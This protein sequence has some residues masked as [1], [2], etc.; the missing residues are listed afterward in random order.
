MSIL[1]YFR[2]EPSIPTSVSTG[3]S[4]RVVEQANKSVSKA[5]ERKG[6]GA[7]RKRKARQHSDETRTKLGKYASANGVAAAQRH[8]KKEF[9]DL[10]ESTIRKY[11][12]LYTKELATRAKRNDTNEITG[13]ALVQR[14]RGRPLCLGVNLDSEVQRY[15]VALRQAGTPVTGHIVLA[16]A[17]GIIT[18]KDRSLLAENGGHIT[19]TRGWAAS[20]LKRMGFV[21]R[22]ATTKMNLHS[23]SSILLKGKKKFLLEISAM[24]SEHKIPDDLIINWDQTGLN[25]VPS[26]SW[27]LKKEGSQRVELVS[28]NDKR[29]IT[30]TFA[31]TLSGQFLPIQILYSGKIPRCHPHFAFPPEFDIWHSSTHW[32]NQEI[33]M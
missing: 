24:V 23:A 14:K 10:P 15:V 3:L 16:A 17:E 21:K 33:V 25:L 1:N 2:K 9:G 18:A 8:F 29:M 22:K 13:T 7:G 11:K 20:I 26:G 32:A 5:L 27:T 30:A 6:E 4:E 12:G 28:Q 31:I 19:L